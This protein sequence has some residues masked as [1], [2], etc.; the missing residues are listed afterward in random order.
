V[1]GIARAGGA[2]AATLPDHADGMASG[3]PPDA[4][5][6]AFC[7]G[8]GLAQIE[9]QWVAPLAGH[10]ARGRLEALRLF[11]LGAAEPLA[12]RVTRRDLRRFW[13]RARPLAHA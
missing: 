11:V 6:L 9:R 2:A 13:R 4:S 8:L 10:L 5:V 12:R 7:G 1:R 3:V